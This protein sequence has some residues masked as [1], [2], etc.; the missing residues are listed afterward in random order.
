MD[1]LKILP[2]SIAALVA[3]C[4][5]SC[6]TGTTVVRSVSTDTLVITKYERDSIYLHDSVY[7]HERTSGDTVYIEVTRW[8]DR[9]RDRFVHDT[10]RESRTDSVPVPYPVRMEVPAPLSW[11]QRWLMWIGGAAIAAVV[12]WMCIKIRVP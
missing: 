7:V 6:K 4:L 2:F 12:I 9:Y 5:A 11:W 8:R 1:R 10:I 3:I